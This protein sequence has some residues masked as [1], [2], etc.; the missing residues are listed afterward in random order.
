MIHVSC[1]D[2]TCGLLELNSGTIALFIDERD[3]T[4]YLF[5]RC[6]NKESRESTITEDTHIFH[7][8]PPLTPAQKK[9]CYFF[10]INNLN[11]LLVLYFL[12]RVIVQLISLKV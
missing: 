9:T 11:T 1:T 6:E 7:P 12:A 8:P 2:R 3:V 5:Q 4:N 10:E